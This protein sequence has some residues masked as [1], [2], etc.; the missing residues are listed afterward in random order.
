MQ[1]SLF[2]NISISSGRARRGASLSRLSKIAINKTLVCRVCKDEKP[3]DEFPKDRTYVAGISNRCKTCKAVSDA[4]H[5]QKNR[6]RL[7]AINARRRLVPENREHDKVVSARW[8]DNNIRLSMVAVA[9][10]TAREKGWEFSITADDLFI[11]QFCPLLGIELKRGKI[12]NR[13]AAPSIDRI[14]SD[15]GYIPG[16][17]WVISFRANRIKN[18]AT[19]DELLQIAQRLKAYERGELLREGCDSVSARAEKADR[20]R[21]LISEGGD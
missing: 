21:Q 5:Y 14:D 9:R 3:I 12:K 1:K 13:D 2:S 15:K 17:V 6:E 4:A 18:N 10:R 11:P 20:P 16:N 8:K 7:N 19:S